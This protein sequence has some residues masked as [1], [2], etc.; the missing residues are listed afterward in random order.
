[1]TERWRVDARRGGSWDTSGAGGLTADTTMLQGVPLVSGGERGGV[2]GR[3]AGGGFALLQPAGQGFVGLAGSEAGGEAGD[4]EVVVQLGPV[5]ALAAAD[6]TPIGALLGSGVRERRGPGER[7]GNGAAIGEIDDQSA[8]ARMYGLGRRGFG[9]AIPAGRVARG[10]AG[11]GGASWLF[12]LAARRG[13]R[14]RVFG[15][16]GRIARPRLN[17]TGRKWGLAGAGRRGG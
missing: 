7:H 2:Q 15:A 9:D 12:G 3:G 1:M 17:G 6:E 13:W 4:A 8:V 10:L 14:G 16:E 5:N 11:R